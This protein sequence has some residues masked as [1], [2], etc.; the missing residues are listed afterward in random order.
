MV[1]D[2]NIYIF[3]SKKE[4][5]EKKLSIWICSSETETWMKM[6]VEEKKNPQP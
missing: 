1:A 5:G 2:D 3:A 6:E 4:I